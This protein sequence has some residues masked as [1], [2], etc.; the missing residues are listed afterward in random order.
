MKMQP[1]SVAGIIARA[2]LEH[3]AERR[4]QEEQQLEE[5]FL[6]GTNAEEERD[7]EEEFY[8]DDLDY[9]DQQE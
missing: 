3:V 7:D 6:G 2:E 5:E 9:Q 1:G 8:L 4:D